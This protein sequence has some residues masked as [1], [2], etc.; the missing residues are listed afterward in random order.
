M[1]MNNPVSIYSFHIIK[2]IC[3]LKKCHLN[4]IVLETILWCKIK[5]HTVHIVIEYEHKEIYWTKN[6]SIEGPYEYWYNDKQI[7]KKCDYKNGEL[8]GSYKT[9]WKSG[10][11]FE[12]R[13]YKNGIFTF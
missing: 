12:E 8:N 9:W 2:T 10:I 1:V 3:I 6:E 7:G 11:A 13:V 5:K 4:Q